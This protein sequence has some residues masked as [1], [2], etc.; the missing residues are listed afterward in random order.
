MKK[1]YWVYILLA[2]VIAW[3][4]F[5]NTRLQINSFPVNAPGLP[6]SFDG[7]QIAHISDLHNTE[8]GTGNR[9]LLTLLEQMQPDIIA[10]TGDLIDSR[11]TDPEVAIQFAEEAVKI[12]P[13]YYVPGNHESR[14]SQYPQFVQ[15]LAEAGVTVLAN[16]SVPLNRNG[17]A[18]LLAGAEDPAFASVDTFSQ[19]LSQLASEE[20]TILL[21]HRPEYFDLYCQNSFALVLSG[22]V[23][24]GQFQLPVLGGVLAPGQG[25]FP[26]Y[27]SG[28]YTCENTSMVVS[29]GLGNSVFPFRLN[30]PPEVILITLI[31]Q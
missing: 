21:S 19:I 18:I 9:K 26:E 1:R 20:F 5:E 30:N 12:A 22:H 6:D 3:G 29:R 14:I 15:Q 28:L 17:E 11:R 10:I 2:A 13:C 7:F 4:F 16:R 8:F 27:D 23:H 24:G 31:K 25:F